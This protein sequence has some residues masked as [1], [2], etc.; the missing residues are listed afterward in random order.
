M[1][2]VN[3]HRFFQ[4]YLLI[5]GCTPAGASGYACYGFTHFGWPR[6]GALTTAG[7]LGQV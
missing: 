1:S 7:I 2:V 5:G 6:R 4:Q 3:V